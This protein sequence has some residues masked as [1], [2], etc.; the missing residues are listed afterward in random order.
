MK[1]SNAAVSQPIILTSSQKKLCGN[2]CRSN[3]PQ[4]LK[5]ESTENES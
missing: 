4:K 3:D 5:L 2:R 1:H